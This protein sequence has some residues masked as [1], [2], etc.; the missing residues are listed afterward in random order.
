MLPLAFIQ[1]LVFGITVNTDPVSFSFQELSFVFLLVFI[2]HLAVAHFVFLELAFEPPS[3]V[4][5]VVPDHLLVVP[6]GSVE[7]VPV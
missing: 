7:L 4:E 5:L 1:H 3:F 6:P 2:H